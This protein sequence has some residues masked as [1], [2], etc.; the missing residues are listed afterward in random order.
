M[1]PSAFYFSLSMIFLILVANLSLQAQPT[2]VISDTS[3]KSIVDWAR[4]HSFFLQNTEPEIGDSDLNPFVKLIKTAGVVALGEPAH[5]FHEPLSFRNRMFRF[6]VKKLDFTTIAL[7]TDFAKSSI[8]NNYVNG[9]TSS[10][11]Q[12]AKALSSIADPTK[13]DI[14]LLQ[15][16]RSYNADP[17]HKLKIKLYG[18][19]VQ[20]IGLPGST[21]PGHASIDE[22]LMYLARMDSES[23]SRFR[24]ALSPYLD[25]LSVANY[26]LLS[27]LEHNSLSATLDDMIALFEHQ[28]MEFLTSGT[29]AAYE[30]AYRN[31]VAARQ[32]DRIVRL[33][34][35]EI[36]GT[37]PAE[38]WRS[39]CARDASMAENVLWMLNQG[40]RVFVYS[41]NGHIKNAPMEGGVWNAFSRPPNSAG[42]YLR[43]EL[44]NRL[45][46]VGISFPSFN[47]AQP[48]SLDIALS[49][50]GKPRFLID[51]RS[52]QKGSQV[53][54]WLEQRRPMQ[55]NL[56]TYQTLSTSEAFDAIIY[57]N[58][59]TPVQRITSK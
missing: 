12:A 48:G 42:Q 45:V 30:W 13:E 39:F 15:W 33:L 56:M 1:T 2:A 34:P 17:A 7:E 38:A 40:E 10:V 6:L 26:P 32:R 47:G 52:V 31:A 55:A 43:S 46:I 36:P 44:G 29:K 24:S 19:D 23:Y 27:D 57:I 20:L 59:V 50:V 3:N 16:M 51:L 9:G 28:K 58:K 49:K 22:A 25:R 5:G 21:E 37:I 18:M 4:T 53:A 35:P 8:A 11:W 41:H 54:K 14:E